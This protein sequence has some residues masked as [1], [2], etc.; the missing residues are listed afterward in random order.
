MEVSAFSSFCRRGFDMKYQD[1]YF[2][3]SFYIIHNKFWIIL[4]GSTSFTTERFSS[5]SHLCWC[6]CLHCL[7]EMFL[8]TFC[9]MK[10]GIGSTGWI[11]NWLFLPFWGY[12]AAASTCADRWED[13]WLYKRWHWVRGSHGFMG[14]QPS[15]LIKGSMSGL[16]WIQSFKFE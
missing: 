8:K 15:L 7:V 3:V 6:V 16:C 5:L 1:Y 13:C 2:L 4:M 9:M 11:I 14:M 10:E 12:E